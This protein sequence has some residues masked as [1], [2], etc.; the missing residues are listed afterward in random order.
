MDAAKIIESDFV[1]KVNLLCVQ[2]QNQLNEN[3]A[4]D[5]CR[6]DHCSTSFG[7]KKIL[8]LMQF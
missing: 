1:A 3:L 7:K 2:N 5:N 6:V 8:I 4:K